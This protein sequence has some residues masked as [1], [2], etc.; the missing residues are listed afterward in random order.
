MLLGQWQKPMPGFGENKC[1]DSQQQRLVHHHTYSG[2][3]WEY[4]FA[5]C[6]NE[7]S[8]YSYLCGLAE[9]TGP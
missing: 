2:M 5:I 3:P 6:L 9:Q 7:Y 8:I 1:I 4:I